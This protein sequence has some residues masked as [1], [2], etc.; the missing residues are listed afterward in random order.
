M[1]KHTVISEAG[2]ILA[3]VRRAK[4]ETIELASGAILE[5][6]L[7]F[8]QVEPVEPAEKTAKAKK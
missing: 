6:A 5:A 4:G 1:K 2:F 3:G 7:R 8:K